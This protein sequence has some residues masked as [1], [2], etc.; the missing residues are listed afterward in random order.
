M[1]YLI[2]SQTRLLLREVVVRKSQWLISVLTAIALIG[3]VVIITGL[4][5]RNVIGTTTGKEI[6]LILGTGLGAFGVEAIYFK[7]VLIFNKNRDGDEK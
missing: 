1:K 2:M 4:S 3:Y 6:A 7:I 5:S